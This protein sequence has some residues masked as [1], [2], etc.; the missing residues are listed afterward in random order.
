MRRED[1]VKALFY[2]SV[3]GTCDNRCSKDTSINECEE[4]TSIMFAEYEKELIENF[5][6]FAT[7]EWFCD[8]FRTCSEEDYY[9]L[10]KDLAKLFMKKRPK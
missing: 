4:C 9:W 2:S 8:H 1:I 7:K 3:E 5:I 6:K 10:L